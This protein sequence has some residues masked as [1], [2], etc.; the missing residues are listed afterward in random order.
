M[1]RIILSAL[2]ALC[3]ACASAHTL[4]V[5]DPLGRGTVQAAADVGLQQVPPPYAPT[6]DLLM[7]EPPPPAYLTGDLALRFGVSDRTDVVTRAGFSGAEVGV[8][9]WLSNGESD[10]SLSA[11]ATA[12]VRPVYGNADLT[13]VQGAGGVMNVGFLMELKP[14]PGLHLVVAPTSHLIVRQQLPVERTHDSFLTA[15]SVVGSTFGVGLDVAPRWRVMGEAGWMSGPT[16]PSAF[17]NPLQPTLQFGASV[18]YTLPAGALA[19]NE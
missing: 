3:L 13:F 2:A 18:Q 1:T 16:Q 4:Q 11:L 14:L 12:N 6:P 5:A 19:S 7:H 10:F 8:K 15:R 9:H 17:V